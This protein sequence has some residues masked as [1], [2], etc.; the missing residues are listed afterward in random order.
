MAKILLALFLVLSSL[1]HAQEIIPGLIPRFY[2]IEAATDLPMSPEVAHERAKNGFD[3]STIDPATNTNIWN[4]NQNVIPEHK[5]LASN[6]TVQFVKELP[7]K[8]GQVRFTVLTN[9]NR[10]LIILLSKKIHTNLLRRNILAK[11]G[12]NTQPM[13]WVPKLKINFVDTIERDLLKEEMKDKLL[14]GTER[15]I[16]A[17]QDL[18]ITIQDALALTPESEIY[19][20]ASG[21]MP[22][23]VHMGRRLLRAPY[24]PLALVDTT[25]SVNLMPWQSGRMVLNHIKLNHTQDLDTSYGASWEDARWIGRRMARLTRADFEEIVKK[26]SYPAAVEK[27]LIEKIIARRNDL[28][29]MLDLNKLS[30][31]IAFNP[32]V[33]SVDGLKDGEIVQEFFEGYSSRFSYGDP[34]SPFSAS[35]LGSFALS[36]AQSELLSVAV[37]KLNTYLGTDDEANYI[38]KLDAIIK[39][40]GPFFTTKAIAMPTF[41]GSLIVSRDIVTGS[42]LGTNNKVQLV[43]NLG[44]SID[45]GVFG[46]VEGLPIPLTFKGGAGMSFQR[47]FSHVKP[48]ASLK[49]SLKEPYK[50]MMVPLLLK[51]IGSKIDKLSSATAENQEALM[52]SVAQ[53]LKSTLSIG[54][55]FIITDSLV[56]NIFTEAE[57]SISQL[58]MLDKRILKVYARVQSQRMMVSRF[59][60][61]RADENTFHVYQDYGKNLKLM[62]TLKLKSFVPLLAFNGRWNKATVETHFYPVSLHPR[63]VS[64]T[65]LKAL[66]SSLF[67]LNHDALDDVVTPH[68]VEHAIKEGGNTWQFLIFKRNS[69][70]SDQSMK[71]THSRGGEKKDIHRRYDA[72]TTGTDPE[73]YIVEAVNSLIQS[74]TKSDLALSQVQTLNPGFTVGGKAKNK[75]FTSE[76][77]GSRMT[78]SFQRILNGWRVTPKKMKSY[79]ELI[80]REAGKK[81]FDVLSVINTDSILLYQI[82]FYYTMTQEGVD[83]LLITPESRLK[84]IIL[85]YGQREIEEERIDGFVG[86]Y[87]T[88]LKKIRALLKSPEPEEGMKKYHKWLKAFQDDV[89]IAGLEELVGKD[90]LA[91]QGRIEGFRQGDENGDNPIFS[92]VYG[93]LPL[94][95]HVTPTQAV[96][97]NWGILEGELLANWMMERAL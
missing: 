32:Q 82:S 14:A 44:F 84:Q 69:V 58:F 89:T 40:E 20:L 96:M 36:R 46:G 85:T 81:V 60:L 9:D 72:V 92:N 79:L 19:N 76:Y 88:E 71:L 8:N 15:W 16:K 18:T 78:T 23:E 12:Y 94:P 50:N 2:S 13:T 3:L 21:V 10:E 70:G 33:S 27:L 42:Y 6:E 47:V 95:L 5:L 34:E 97:Q 64:V 55:S 35:E 87:F 68:K 4:P 28:M 63:N 7:S 30:P 41:H 83:Q 22:Q 75:I 59:H 53:D 24:V 57:L 52:Q 54:E 49:K 90:N 91:Y 56:P 62:L 37:S 73:G 11:L 80:N 65:T 29:A 66:R 45:A 25:E 26:A 93:E 39:D 51:D 61:H 86:W 74:L 77:D 38:E 17:E 67:A 31:D 43:D 1:V 48:V